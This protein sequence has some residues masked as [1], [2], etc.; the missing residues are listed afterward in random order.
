MSIA[1]RLRVTLAR[2]PWLYWAIVAALA[3]AAGLFVMRA[4]NG[5]ETARQSWGTNTPGVRR[6]ARRRAWRRLGR[7]RRD[8]TAAGADG[9]RRCRH[10]AG[11]WRR[12]PAADRRRR[13]DRHPRRRPPRR[14]AVADPAALAGGRHR[15]TGGV[16]RPGRRRRD[17][18]GRWR[19]HRRRGR[20]R[21][22]RRRRPCWWP[23]PPTRRRRW[24]TPRRPATSPCSSGRELAASGAVGDDAEQ[25][26]AG[27]D[28]IDHEGQEASCPHQAQQSPH[29]QPP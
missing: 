17:G 19:R 2:S 22:H 3:G 15:R 10:R 13:G 14:A 28:A 26:D 1:A 21:R 6:G 27:G 25:K 11:H 5:V 7:Q 23:F 12:C 8:A 4:A 20:R 16:R 9:P 18:D 24:P 29:C